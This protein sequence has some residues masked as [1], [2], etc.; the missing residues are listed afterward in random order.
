M[1]IT[2]ED[3]KTLEKYIKHTLNQHPDL[4]STYK[5]QG[6]SAT[7]YNF[8]ILWASNVP[9]DTLDSLFGYLGDKCME[10]AISKITNVKKI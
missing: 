2:T 9:Q 6:L 1:K 5:D 8:D 4:K 7:R 10:T 3:Y